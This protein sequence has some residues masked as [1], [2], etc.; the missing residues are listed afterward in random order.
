MNMDDPVISDHFLPDLLTRLSDQH[1]HQASCSILAASLGLMAGQGSDL[2]VFSG[3]FPDTTVR[4]DAP[5]ATSTIVCP[6]ILML[7]RCH[8]ACLSCSHHQRCNYSGIITRRECIHIRHCEHQG[9][10]T[11]LL[12]IYTECTEMTSIPQSR[13]TSNRIAYMQ[14]ICA[15]VN[16]SPPPVQSSPWTCLQLLVGCA[17]KQEPPCCMLSRG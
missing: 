6:G 9:T 12:T 13:S 14:D 5:A 17:R 4:A 7:G 1:S 2:S 11:G 3:D 16:I 15:F 10:E 8:E